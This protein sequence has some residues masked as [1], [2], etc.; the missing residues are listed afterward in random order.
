[1][2]N[3]QTGFGE[4]TPKI[5]IFSKSECCKM[6][7]YMS[8]YNAYVICIGGHV[9]I[10][11]QICICLCLTYMHILLDVERAISTNGSNI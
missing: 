6:H 2:R 7:K 11:P 4:K 5:C 10:L 8:F 3:I 1:M 9:A